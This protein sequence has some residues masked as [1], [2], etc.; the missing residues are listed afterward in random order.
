MTTVPPNTLPSQVKS[1]HMTQFGPAL[2]VQNKRAHHNTKRATLCKPRIQKCNVRADARENVMRTILSKQAKCQ[3]A[4]MT[5][6]M[7][8]TAFLSVV[9]QMPQL[10]T[11]CWSMY[12]RFVLV[13]EV[14]QAT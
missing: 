8:R 14:Q 9:A 2:C 3:Q 10:I 11:T 4:P 7:M 12:G 13:S 6:F 1:K 5:R